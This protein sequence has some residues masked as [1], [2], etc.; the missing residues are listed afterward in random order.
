MF[1]LWIYEKK[2]VLQL[3]IISWKRFYL[4]LNQNLL[5]IILVFSILNA[6]VDSF[7]KI[8]IASLKDKTEIFVCRDVTKNVNAENVWQMKNLGIKY[9]LMKKVV[10]MKVKFNFVP[11]FFKYFMKTI[12]FFQIGKTIYNTCQTNTDCPENFYC[13]KLEGNL[14]MSK[15]KSGRMCKSDEECSCGKCT[16]VKQMTRLNRPPILYNVCLCWQFWDLLI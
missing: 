10:K 1:S 14:C 6:R 12:F 2:Q 3:M 13:N 5:I 7:A 11:K 9:V 16:Q 4:R 8:L 15:L